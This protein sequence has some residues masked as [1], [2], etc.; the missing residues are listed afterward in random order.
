M[1]IMKMKLF[2][3]WCLCVLLG[4]FLFTS[5]LRAQYYLPENRVWAFG[6]GAGLDFNSGNPGGFA[7]GFSTTAQGGLWEA[8]A[9][10]S[11]AAGNLLFYTNGITIWNRN[12]APMPNANT[13]Y[14]GIRINS[15]TESSTQGALIVPVPDTPHKYYVF[16]LTCSESRT[17]PVAG[18]LYYSV[19]DMQLN[20]GLGDVEPGRKWIE[21][22]TGMAEKLIAIPGAC[23]NI[24][25]VI[26]SKDTNMFKAY[27]VTSSGIR[28]NAVV[29]YSG[30][31]GTG[32]SLPGARKDFWNIGALAASHDY[33]HIA[34]CSYYG[35]TLE[36]FDFDRSTGVVSSGVTLDSNRLHNWSY[37]GVC[38]SPDDSKLYVTAPN[39]NDPQGRYDYYVFQYDLNAGSLSAIR[40]SRALIGP[41]G[42][43]GSTLALGPDGK[44]YF[45]G[46]ASDRV[47]VISAPSQPPALCQYNSNVIPLVPGTR[48][49]MGL[50]NQF[51]KPLSD[52][53]FFRHPDT[54]LCS[55][56][57]I[58]LGVSGRVGCLWQD[59]NTN[60]IRVIT[61][62]GTYWVRSK[63]DCGWQVDTFVV[64]GIDVS[65]SL[66]VDTS[67]CD[68]SPLVLHVPLA[69]EMFQW[70]DGS[71]ADSLKIS[72]S[73]RYWVHVRRQHCLASDT[74][75]VHILVMRKPDLG[76]DTT[77]CEQAPIRIGQ[78]IP[79]A[80][81]QWNNGAVTPT[82]EVST[83]GLYAVRI[84]IEGCTAADTIAVVAMPSPD[85]DLGDDRYICPGQTVVLDA[86]YGDNSTY[87]WSTGATTSS[88]EVA[89]PGKVSVTVTSAY[90]CVASDEVVLTAYFLPVVWLGPDTVLCT[91]T[92]MLL[93][94]QARYADRLTWSDGS[95]GQSLLVRQE[96]LYFVRAENV[97][98]V[99]SD[100]VF[101]QEI[102]CDIWFPEAFTPNGDGRND[103]FR[104]LGNIH[105]LDAFSLSIFNRWGERVYYSDDATMGW[106]GNHKGVES[107]Q[108]TYMYLLEYATKG[109]RYRKKGDV[110]LIR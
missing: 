56:G 46:T 72:Q 104:A 71:T 19:V 64:R 25:V 68:G 97:C 89:D 70:S 91:E 62:P 65:F 54:S 83:T 52:T 75:E 24:W 38:F 93:S 15:V 92:P 31:S 106:D 7:S 69:G 51:V 94:P 102:A 82:I 6:S 41:C 33:R 16:S 95:T 81:Y 42:Q 55:N 45:Q 90:G 17:Y 86:R 29:S 67:V 3:K 44:L 23:N 28:N 50:Y 13:L 59:G 18:R 96:G 48:M 11:D 109:A 110:Q 76:N 79:G 60:C 20:S 47:S 80:S 39:P 107:Q 105:S 27:E 78:E 32:G 58:Q 103:L 14:G 85:V 21:L 37:Y 12:H 34:M 66:G 22:D 108:G 100:T 101:I 84:D 74:I 53:T 43:D 26:H 49:N 57:N 4:Q 9:A 30:K 77:I 98:G 73:G 36:L 35:N 1:E 61:T 2:Y 5:A 88:V 10:V 63:S 87:L 8:A 99:T 40:S